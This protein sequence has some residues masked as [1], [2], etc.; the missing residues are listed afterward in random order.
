MQ[1][2]LYVLLKCSFR[3]VKRINKV[4]HLYLLYLR[5]FTAFKMTRTMKIKAN[6][7][8]ASCNW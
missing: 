2:V 3:C 5:F 1:T 8:L 6:K 7:A 4:K